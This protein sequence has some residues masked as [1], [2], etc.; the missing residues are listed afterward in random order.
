[1]AYIGG[2]FGVGIH[3]TLEAAVYGIP[4]LF[5]PNYKK[6]KEAKDLIEV[7]GGFSIHSIAEFEDKMNEFITHPEVMQAAGK[8]AG[9]FVAGQVGATDKIL[10]DILPALDH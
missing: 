1:M 8:A 3:N 9:D 5:G 2:G 7:G 6:F 4:V 10:S